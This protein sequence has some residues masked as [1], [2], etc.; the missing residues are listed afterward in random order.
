MRKTSKRALWSTVVGCSLVAGC[1]IQPPV[2]RVSRKLDCESGKACT[3]TVDVTCDRFY[4]CRLAVDYDLILVQ[5]RGQE[6]A[7]TWELSGEAGA[8]F[9]GNGIVIDSADFDCTQKREK[10][11]FGC[12]DKH[13]DFGVLKYT[14][15]VNVPGSAFGPRGVPSL[16]P[17][18]V[19]N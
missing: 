17:W 1:A 13:R 4:G 19:N 16:D 2:E 5:G 8:E 14:I 6:T 11:R 18:I 12:S 9:A 7:I 15:N 10:R 3:V